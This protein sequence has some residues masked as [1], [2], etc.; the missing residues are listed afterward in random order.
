MADT[1]AQSLTL[2]DVRARIDAIDDQILR[3]VSER[4]GLATS[5]AQA[6]LAAGETR[7]GLRSAREAQVLRR[8]IAET[9]A[10]VSAEVT[11]ALWRQIMA[12]SLARQGAFHISLWGGKALTRTL[13][14][15]R[16]R[17][18]A[19]VTVRGAAR[20]EDAIAAARTQG[21]VGVLALATDTPWW[22]SLL[23]QPTLNV[24]ASL[25]CLR[26]WGP[27]T[28]LAVAEIEVDP[29]G[30]D[31][32]FWVTD[33]PQTPAAIIAYLGEI[34][35]AAELLA[36]VGGC[37]LFTLAGYVQRQDARLVRAPGQLK[38]VIG[39]ASMPLDV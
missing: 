6:K 29:S 25:P 17:F 19:A 8:L 38:G 18:G 7:F 26:R 10:G 27:A 11:I 23:D 13:E 16:I 9:D 14:L 28:A 21:G 35:L 24:F 15:T 4:A 22:R 12:D 20:P 30:A 37:R 1:P 5:V 2:G 39:A 34:G 31:E 33:A 32:T 36:D 3:L